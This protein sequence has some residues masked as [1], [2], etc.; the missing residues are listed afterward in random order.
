MH[1]LQNTKKNF[2]FPSFNNYKEETQT[3]RRNTNI[4]AQESDD[5]DIEMGGYLVV[6]SVIGASNHFKFFQCPINSCCF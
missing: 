1:W 2:S 4:L 3:D 5:H 6:V